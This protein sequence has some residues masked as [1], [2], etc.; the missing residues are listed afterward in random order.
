MFHFRRVVFSCQFKSKIG[1][2]LAKT[3]SL[4][5]N[6][7]LNE[8]PIISRTHTHP[9][10][11][12]HHTDTHILVFPLALALSIH[13]QQH[14]MVP[15]TVTSGHVYDRFLWTT[16]LFNLQGSV[17]LILDKTSVI[18]VT[19][20]IDLS[21]RPFIPLPRVLTLVECLLFLINLWS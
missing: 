16:H 9:S 4:R 3:T 5:V 15:V 11:S 13:N 21:S 10:H 12:L 20:P 2:I 1:N 7:Y 8:T 18:R 6:L 19:I 14:P 17:G